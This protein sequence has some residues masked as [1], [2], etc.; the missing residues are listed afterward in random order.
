MGEDHVFVYGGNVD[1]AAGFFGVAEFADEGLREEEGAFE[2]DVEDGVVVGFGDVP[3]VGAL[4]D[5]GV[6]DE[7][8]AGTEL[9]PGLLDEV[10]A[11]GEVGDVGVD[12][13]GLAAG[14]GD[15]VDGGLGL[16][17]VVA[18][19]DDEVCAFLRETLCYGLTDA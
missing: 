8:V 4:F 18:V 14:G 19:V 1:D 10:G 9:L 6:V 5:A 3:E 15:L 12:H 13:D 17:D 2:I 7:D 16:L 11:V